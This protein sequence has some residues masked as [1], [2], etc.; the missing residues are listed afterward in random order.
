[1]AHRIHVGRRTY[2]R[3]SMLLL[4]L[5]LSIC[6]AAGDMPSFTGTVVDI[7]TGKPLEGAYAVASYYEERSSPGVTKQLCVKTRG[8]MT[9]PDGKFS[10][11]VEKR[12]GMSPSFVTAIKPGYYIIRAEHPEATPYS[13]KRVLLK[14]QDELKPVFLYE[15]GD[16][17][18]GYARK[19]SDVEAT[20]RF[21][22]IQLAERERLHDS[23]RS[24][25]GVRNLIELTRKIDA[26]ND[27]R[28][29]K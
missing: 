11:P 24:I 23:K 5:Q 14:K 15:S 28:N 16:Q 10:F 9:G 22:E 7:E 19:S 13:N 4:G 12:D 6:L 29:K 17:I 18:C 27:V 1:M 8:M 3:G 26:D 21:L 25:D 20:I 2:K